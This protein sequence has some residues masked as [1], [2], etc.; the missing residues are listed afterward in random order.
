VQEPGCDGHSVELQFGQDVGDFKRM[1]EIRLS[2][3]PELALVILGRDHVTPLDQI[4]R[5]IRVIGQDFLC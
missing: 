5:G 2:V 1:R 4:H 3:H